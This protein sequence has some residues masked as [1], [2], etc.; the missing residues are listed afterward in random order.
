MDSSDL[1]NVEWT[2]PGTDSYASRMGGAMD[3]M[4]NVTTGMQFALDSGALE[5]GGPEGV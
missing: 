2:M 5:E 1:N 3:D 4:S